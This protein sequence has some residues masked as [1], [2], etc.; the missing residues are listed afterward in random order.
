MKI[1]HCVKI[2]DEEMK[3]LLTARDMI[4]QVADDD[5]IAH[6]FD[7]GHSFEISDFSAWFED[8]IDFLEAWKNFG[9]I[10]PKI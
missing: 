3:S 1:C 4:R 9:L 5:M 6:D 8:V 10:S 7:D 2:S